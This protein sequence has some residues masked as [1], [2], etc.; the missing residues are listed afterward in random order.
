MGFNISEIVESK[1]WKKFMA[2]LY[3]WGAAIVIIG[4]L[5]KI[6][7][8]PFSGVLLTVGLLTEA[9]IF[10]FSA[11]EPLHE[12][13]D[14]SLVYPELAGMHEEELLDITPEKKETKKS[15]L[16]RFED[17]VG[18]ADLTPDVFEKLGKGFKTLSDTTSKMS[19]ISGATV[20]TQ[21]YVTNIKT[22]SSSFS[23]L[24]DS[25]NQS[26]S[27]LNDNANQLANSYAKAAEM[28]STSGGN[29]A[30]VLNNVTNTVAEKI[31]EAGIQ[32]TNTYKAISE[33]LQSGA[34]NIVDN[35]KTYAQQLE[36]ITK[37]LSAL[38]AV[39]ELQLQGTNQQLKA[40]EQ[41]YGGVNE[42]MQNLKDSVE[43]TKKY[44]DEVSKLGQNL[45]ALNTIYGN[46]LSAMNFTKV[47]S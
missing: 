44:R 31:S 26:V 12:E 42:M 46:M 13:I 37:N 38:N 2:K 35:N 28:I 10:F 9:V 3:G 17:L 45:A 18:T 14:W 7:H 8:W 34:S 32:V 21:E 27:A 11:F 41:L 24:N 40:T 33:S 25:Y 36:H 43:D 4:A 23:S 15:A 16:E 22:A 5:F 39:Y 6:M 47:N 1:G 30:N 19:D 29:T 20:A